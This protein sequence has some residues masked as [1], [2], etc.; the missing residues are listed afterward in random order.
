MNTIIHIDAG[1]GTRAYTRGK[2]SPDGRLVEGEYCREL[3]RRLI[4]ALREIG[5][6]AREVVPEDQ[7]IA[8]DERC[9]RVNRAISKEPTARHLFLSVHLNAAPTASCNA[10]GW[11]RGASGWCVYTARKC[12]AESV[13]MARSLYGVADEF[14]LRGNRCVPQEGFWRADYRVLVNT[15]CPAVLTE[16]LFMTNPTEVDWLLSP[17]GMDSLVNLHLLGLCRYLGIPAGLVIGSM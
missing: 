10:Q 14:G 9:A 2:R 3:V 1:H 4:P 12:S 15:K 11:C 16:S 5:L 8:L 17:H 7:D 6:D 13:R